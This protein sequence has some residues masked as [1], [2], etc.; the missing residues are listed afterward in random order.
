MMDDGRKVLNRV[1]FGWK[2]SFKQNILFSINL[3]INLLEY[4][5]LTVLCQNC[6]ICRRV[7]I[8][9]MRKQAI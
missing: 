5:Y 3:G 9:S 6:K 8:F 2:P 1:S 4:I 7:C